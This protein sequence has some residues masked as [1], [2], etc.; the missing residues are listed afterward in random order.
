MSV[1][2]ITHRVHPEVIELLSEHAVVI[3][4]QSAETLSRPALLDRLAGA[5]GVMTFM[6]DHVDDVFLDAAPRLQV[7]AAALK[8]YDNHDVDAC[9]RRGVWVTVREDL[10]TV[11]TAELAIGLIIGL[12]RRIP[13]A[14]RFMRDGRFSGWR[15]RFY[16]TGLAGSCVGIIGMGAVGRALARRLRAFDA[17]V[18]FHDRR[19]PADLPG[20]VESLALGDLL[21]RSDFVL[22]LVH[23][24]ADSRHLIGAAALSRIKPGSYL[25]NVGRGSVVDERAV[26]EALDSGRLAGYAADVFEME[27]W[28]RPDRP[29]SVPRELLERHERTL[30]TPHIG[31]AV[32]AARRA[33]ELDAAR[34]ILDAF[35][36]V[37]PR[38]AVNRPAQ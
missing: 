33:I 9:T 25:V 4:N 3:A 11:P 8:G 6:P 16:G 15:P 30:L 22:P 36:G 20:D 2:V 19:R 34:S 24:T 12:A 31:S 18:V 7:I 10:L 27:D 5:H 29:R 23:L 17:R 32:D 1:V 14:D 26:I 28:A 35:R 21:E 38:G 13:S 37:T